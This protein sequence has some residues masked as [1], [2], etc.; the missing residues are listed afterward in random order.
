MQ[1]ANGDYFKMDKFMSCLHP[2]VREKVDFE[3]PKNYNGVVPIS[4]AKSRKIK[5][6]IE[7]GMMGYEQQPSPQGEVRVEDQANCGVAAISQHWLRNVQD[8]S[9]QMQEFCL[10]VMD[11][12]K[13][14][15][16][17]GR[18]W[19]LPG[20][21]YNCG[22]EGHYAPDCPHPPRERG[23]IYPLFGRGRGQGRFNGQRDQQ[24]DNPVPPAPQG[25]EEVH[26]DNIIGVDEQVVDVLANKREREGRDTE[27]KRETRARK[28]KGKVDEGREPL[29]T[30]KRR[31][32]HKIKQSDYQLGRDHPEYDSVSDVKNQKANITFGQLLALNPKLQR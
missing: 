24:F 4:Q 12:G 11:R 6:K 2:K 9:E 29:E 10:S 21:C 32:R 27:T 30:S 18:A 13:Q 28:G 19:Q 17:R 25:N 3:S 23:G 20:R 7:Q 8:L 26:R 15:A 14:R 1:L 5:K 31:R 16:G 22:E